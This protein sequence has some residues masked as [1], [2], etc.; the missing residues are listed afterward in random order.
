MRIQVNGDQR[1]IVAST[2]LTL[3]EELSLDPRKVAVERNLEIV[4]RSLHASTTLAEGDRIELVQ[5]VGGG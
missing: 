3:V 1:E 5:F 4:P 2:I